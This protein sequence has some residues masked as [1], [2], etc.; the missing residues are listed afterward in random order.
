[1]VKNVDI[2]Q[3]FSKDNRSIYISLQSLYEPSRD[4]TKKVAC[5]PS[6][7]SDQPGHPPSVI[8]VFAVRMNKAWVLSY[9]LSAQRSEDSDQTGRMPRLIWVFDGRTLIL[10]VLSRGGSY[11]SC[12]S[13]FLFSMESIETSCDHC[14]RKGGL[15]STST[16]AG[17]FCWYLCD[18][19]HILSWR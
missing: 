12:C 1:M 10:F 9:P 19:K 5:A 14:G 6:E 13:L 11:I 4:K 2:Q 18:V 17:I 8:R 15:T 7:N 16:N 3:Y